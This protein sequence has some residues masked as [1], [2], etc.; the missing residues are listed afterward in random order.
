MRGPQRSNFPLR[1]LYVRLSAE[2]VGDF[3]ARIT[4]FRD[5]PRFDEIAELINRRL[6]TAPGPL[7]AT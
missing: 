4:I 6:I 5:T 7:R 2:E 3:Y 1:P